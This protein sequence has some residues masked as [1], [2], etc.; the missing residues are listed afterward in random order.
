MYITGGSRWLLRLGTGITLA[1][2]YIPLRHH[3]EQNFHVAHRLRRYGSGRRLD[4]AD[5]T[6]EH[7][8][9]IGRSETNCKSAYTPRR[10]TRLSLD[11]CARR[12]QITPN[13]R[14]QLHLGMSRTLACLT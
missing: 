2:I 10:S 4:Y 11:V 13:C 7:W 14:R 1:F 12:A 9:I 5:I 6:P 8:G 3:F